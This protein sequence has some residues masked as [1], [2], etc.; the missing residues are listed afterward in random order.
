MKLLVIYPPFA[1]S[2]IMPYS[3]GHLKGMLKNTKAL[4]LNAKF[5]KLKFNINLKELADTRV[6]E[7]NNHLILNGE[8]PE[9]FDELLSL[10]NN[11]KPDSVAFS[12]VYN[13]QCF[14]TRKLIEH[15][16]V[17]VYLGGPT[18]SPKLNGKHVDLTQ[19]PVE[20]KRNPK[21]D[22]SD[23]NKVDY[24]SPEITPAKSSKGCFYKNC[25][26]CTHHKDTP[27]KELPL[28]LDGD[29]LFFIDDM[30][31]LDRLKQIASKVP[32][33]A[34]WWAQLRP[35]KDLVSHLRYLSE[36]GLKSVAW[37]VESGSQ[38]ILN[39]M[40]KGTKVEDISKV[41]RA[42]KEAGMINTVYVM[43]GFPGET[44][45]D[46][47]KTIKF[48]KKHD[49]NIDLVSTSTFGLHKGTEVYNNPEKYDIKIWQEQRTFLDDKIHF[50]PKPKD[51]QKNYR[52]TIEKINKL[53]KEYVL[54]KEQTL[55]L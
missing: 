15:L 51:Y 55:L 54:F 3:I 39:L 50:Y 29:Y 16:E 9:F 23:F 33:N 31:P 26:F 12:L 27:Y 22:F 8:K 52:R 47:L 40:K 18:V 25:A 5:H 53:P 46:F 11:E 43:F 21:P 49:K 10:I 14:Y 48:L 45:E 2:T 13:S 38:K 20:F 28:E 19:L 44:K 30:I 17:P 36:N 34:K 24:L 37:G 4:D 35:T 42:A 1:P 32:K 7:K 41:L 6:H